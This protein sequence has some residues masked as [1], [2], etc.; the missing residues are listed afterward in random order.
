ML[1]VAITGNIASGKSFIGQ[2]LKE[3]GY[4]VFDTDTISHSLLDENKTILQEKFSGLDITEDDKISRKKLGSLVF[5]DKNLK[6]RLESVIHPMVEE[7]LKSIFETQKD[8]KAVFV[9]IPLLFETGMQKLFDKV[10]L[11]YTQDDVRKDRLKS[12]SNLS[13]EEISKRFKSQM[14]QEDKIKMSDFVIDNTFSQ[15]R[16]K[17]ELDEILKKLDIYV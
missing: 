7:K 1:K 13:D 6:Q 8:N 16:T 4:K 12:R 9:E 11:V 14:S 3:K 10:I 17:K 5:N 15:E 2:T